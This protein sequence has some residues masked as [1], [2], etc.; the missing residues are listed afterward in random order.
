MAVV[1]WLLCIASSLL[2][3]LAICSSLADIAADV[4]DS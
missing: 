3:S 4:A 2:S 1:S